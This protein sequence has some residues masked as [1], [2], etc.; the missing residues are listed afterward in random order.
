[1]RWL[2][3]RAER[4]ATV[5]ASGT[6]GTKVL[7]SAVAFMLLLTLGYAF[8]RGVA[9][10][11]LEY[12]CR[13]KSAAGHFTDL[14]AMWLMAAVIYATGP[15]LHPHMMVSNMVA[16]ATSLFFFG[17]LGE[18]SYL[19]TSLANIRGVMRPPA[20]Y[21]FL[22]SAVGL[23][24]LVGYAIAMSLERGSRATSALLMCL[25][26]GYYFSGWI[27][28]AA[29]NETIE[30]HPHHFQLAWHSTL[31]LRHNKDE[32]TVLL[33]WGLLGIFVHG[34]AAYGADSMLLSSANP[35]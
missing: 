32:L 20:S 7:W 6:L 27:T 33:R 21:F 17:A 24:M 3:H 12:A 35:S 25:I 34:V 13:V 19:Q 16:F 29:A 31:L 22:A 14:S 26:L 9:C 18:I 2:K 1:M 10:A 23:A 28:T 30:Y 4:V 5:A 11:Q 15:T 8:Y